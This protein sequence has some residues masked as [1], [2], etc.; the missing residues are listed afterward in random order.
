[1]II[2]IFGDA[3]TFPEGNAATNRI[4]TYAKGFR[5]FGIEV[6]VICFTAEYLDNYNGSIDE[7]KYFH[8]F[9]Q[10]VR[11]RHFVVR[12]LLKFNR[13]FRTVKILK[14][15][16]KNGKISAIN[17]WSEPL[18]TKLFAWFLSKIF[19]TKLIIESSE[20][21]LRNYKTGLI[22]QLQGKILFYIVSH[23]FD[24]AFCISKHLVN[25][26]IS[27]GINPGKLCFV[28]STVD[29][30]RFDIEDTSPFPFRYI[31]YFGSL[32]FK[33]DNVD[34]L[35][36]AFERIRQQHSDIH[37]VLGGICS[38]NDRLQLLSLVKN[39]ELESKV[40]IL[41]YLPRN[42]IISYIK[43]A[44]ILVMVRSHDFYTQVSF[45]S[46]LAEYLSTSKPVITL[47]T[48]EISNF[49]TD[50][51]NCFFVGE[52]SAEALAAKIDYVLNNYELAL[53]VGKKG[54]EL[55]TTIFNYKH[56]AAGMI[57]FINSVNSG[58]GDNNLKVK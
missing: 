34:L 47:N 19:R 20:H 39:F 8:P 3:F 32:T 25:F 52:I 16:S 57:D 55:T 38:D 35:I 7:I 28:P 17:S 42:E 4:Y 24:G 56:Q 36:Y 37:L 27:K 18:P 22:K 49:L 41:E 30:A 50:N 26:Y 40:H 48:G 6:C 33:R 53:E 46:K 31:A 12:Q 51:V 58:S 5:E 29:P 14:D 15:I 54:K 21:P 13:Y 43:N 9:S 10:K 45:P 2:V 23:L 11:N 44:E 1:M